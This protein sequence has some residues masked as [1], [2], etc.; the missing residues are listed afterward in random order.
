LIPAKS[1]LARYHQD[2]YAPCP[3][4]SNHTK[5]QAIVWGIILTAQELGIRIIAEGIENQKEAEWF[6]ANQVT[7]QQGY[8]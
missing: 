7:L 1:F 4:Y 5:K 2:R 3:G 6:V 8:Y